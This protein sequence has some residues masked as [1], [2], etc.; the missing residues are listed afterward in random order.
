MFGTHCDPNLA[1][2]GSFYL[3]QGQ[4]VPVTEPLSVRFVGLVV[5]IH[6]QSV[7]AFHSSEEA[8]LSSGEYPPIALSDA[9]I[10]REHT[11][12]RLVRGKSAIMIGELLVRGMSRGIPTGIFIESGVPAPALRRATSFS[13]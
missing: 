3:V 1:S 5:D 13:H 7:V 4:R 11:P 8:I 9:P 10:A 2:R 12:G 6:D